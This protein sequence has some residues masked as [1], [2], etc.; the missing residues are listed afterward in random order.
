MWGVLT[1][2]ACH[3]GEARVLEPLVSLFSRW[4][5]DGWRIKCCRNLFHQMQIE[6]DAFQMVSRSILQVRIA[7]GTSG[8]FRSS[9][10]FQSS[11]GRMYWYE[12]RRW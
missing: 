10:Y 12:V 7:G 8:R 11:V 9:A 2:F 3:C 6:V 5:L 4:I 1:R